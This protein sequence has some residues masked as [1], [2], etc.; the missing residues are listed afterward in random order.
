MMATGTKKVDARALAAKGL[1]EIAMRGASLRDVME[2]YA[3]RLADP[4]D[5]AL[6]MAL[7][8]EGARWWLRFDPAVDGLLQKS[9]RHK[10]PAVH[11]LLVLGL[12]QLEILQLQDYAAVAATVE[13]ARALQRPQL[14]GLVNA[15]LRR[16]QREREGLMIKLDAQPQTRH[17]HP[18][19]LASALQ[20]DWPAQAEAV[21]L[22]DNAEPPLM[23][24]V[25]RQRADRGALLERLRATDYAAEIHP[26]LSD[27][28][29]LPHST[30][31]TRMP[32]FEDGLFAVQDGSAQIGADLA[33]LS[34]GM[35][36]LDACAA[37][38]GKA[39]HMLERADIDLT[40]LEM[41]ASRAERIQQ[42]LMRLRLN[43]KIVIGD[44][45]APKGWWKGP[46][47]DRILIDAPC[48]A[49]GVMRRRPDVRLHRR[50][51]DIAA[52]HDQQRRIL[53]ALWPLL[54]PGGRLVY[55]TCSMLRAENEVIVD[56][57]LASQADA[58]AVDFSLPVGQA[59]G[60]GW[61]ILPGDGDLDG[62]YY[63]VLQKRA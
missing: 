12:V 49:T 23:L 41:D 25:N 46:A 5:R 4:R 17:A 32:G 19:W 10:D 38:G 6:L 58:Q 31:V 53:S 48:S 59:A 22:A 39:C 3:P 15:V 9:L 14:A 28:L 56:E 18:A 50:E 16:W 63:A 52:M 13:A 55:I 47:F 62:M 44:A 24:R 33:A 61:Q 20:R 34:D 29:V 7:L 35:R 1:A 45:G 30:D 2:R 8:S 51:S 40:A 57:L 36:V 54:A 37:P 42:N 43:A 27:A 11:A 26:W 60:T 21:M